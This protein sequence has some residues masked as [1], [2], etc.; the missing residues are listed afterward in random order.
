MAAACLTESGPSFKKVT[1]MK[2]I[3][4]A[5]ARLRCAKSYI[6]YASAFWL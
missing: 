5:P 6:F 2:Q 1:G 4:G 3:V